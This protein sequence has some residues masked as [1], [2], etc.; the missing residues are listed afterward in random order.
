MSEYYD[1]AGSCVGNI[2]YIYIYIYIAC[3]WK[4]GTCSEESSCGTCSGTGITSEV[5]CACDSN[6]GLKEITA[7]KT[8]VCDNSKGFATTTTTGKCTK[9][10]SGET[11][12]GDK[13]L[14][15]KIPYLFI[16]YLALVIN[17][18]GKEKDD[19]DDDDED[20]NT[21]IIVSCVVGFAVFLGAFA[22]FVLIKIRNIKRC[23]FCKKLLCKSYIHFYLKLFI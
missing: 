6:L 18:E 13:C 3:D 17:Q 22:V 12:E 20:D 2:I 16:F 7:N 5:P 10:K 21:I 8:C 23:C 9:C 11:A 15:G 14:E 4:C 1:N 19:D